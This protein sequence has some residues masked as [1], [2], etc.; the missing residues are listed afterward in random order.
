VS[1]RRVCACRRALTESE[2]FHGYGVG[3][4]RPA[5]HDEPHILSAQEVR[6]RYTETR[7]GPERVGDILGRFLERERQL[8]AGGRR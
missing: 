6:G 3:G 7:L 8:S 2:L 1:E 4:L 5:T